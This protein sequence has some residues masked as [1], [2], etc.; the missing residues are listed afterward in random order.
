MKGAKL[1]DIPKRASMDKG[2][3]DHFINCESNYDFIWACSDISPTFQ[4][5]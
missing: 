5:I 1:L 3:S 2:E 4:N